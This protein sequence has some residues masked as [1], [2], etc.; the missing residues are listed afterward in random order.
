MSKNVIIV[1]APRSGT[2]MTA[3]IFTQ[4]GYCVT[5]NESTD[6]QEASESNPNGFWEAASLRQG[7]AAIFHNVG[8]PY[9]NTWLFDAISDEQAQR[10]LFL[11]RIRNI[12][13]W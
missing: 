13:S 5:E 1:G 2:N 6:L 3:N 12:K 4:Q 11:N 8:F 10:S 7:N 9:V